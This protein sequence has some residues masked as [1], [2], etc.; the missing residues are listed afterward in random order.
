MPPELLTGKCNTK[1][2][3]EMLTLENEHSLVLLSPVKKNAWK[4]FSNTPSHVKDLKQTLP[5]PC[6][7][8]AKV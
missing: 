3:T 5:S 7:F 8:W 4:V 1:N 2:I 6:P